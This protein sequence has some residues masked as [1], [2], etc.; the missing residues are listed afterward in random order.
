[1]V[2]VAYSVGTL[3]AGCVPVQLPLAPLG[4]LPGL[5]KGLPVASCVL[6][7]VICQAVPLDI[8]DAAPHAGPACIVARVTNSNENLSLYPIG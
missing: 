8:L 3:T 2:S 4:C 1:M 7:L 5:H 6:R